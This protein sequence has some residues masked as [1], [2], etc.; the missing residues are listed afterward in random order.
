MHLPAVLAVRRQSIGS[1]IGRLDNMSLPNRREA[2]LWL[3]TA[4][5]RV[6][7]YFMGEQVEQIR[8]FLGKRVEIAGRLTRDAD[9]KLLTIQMRSLEILRD[10]PGPALTD[11]VGLDPDL[12]GGESPQEHLRELRGAS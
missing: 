4:G 8:E 6:A 12:T 5:V 11:L 10:E 7:V 2:G 9:G 1:A 3:E